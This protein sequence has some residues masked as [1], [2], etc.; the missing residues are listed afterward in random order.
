MKLDFQELTRDDEVHK[1]QLIL[2]GKQ[3]LSELVVRQEH[4]MSRLYLQFFQV[5]GIR[6]WLGY[7]V[8]SLLLIYWLLFPMSDIQ[9]ILLYEFL[10]GS[11][12]VIQVIRQRQAHMEELLCTLPI[13][14]ASIFLFHFTSFLVIYLA[15]LGVISYLLLYQFGLTLT[16]ILKLCVLPMLISQSV[17]LLAI[18][19]LDSFYSAAGLYLGAY[20]L[21]AL[22]F[23]IQDVAFFVNLGM[24]I[25]DQM[26]LGM[27]VLVVLGYGYIACTY[28]TFEKERTYEAYD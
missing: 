4:R 12:F 8:F 15:S 2:L 9:I 27:S 16:A 10:L 11:L 21:T 6:S 23:P 13:N 25:N 17:L 3:T 28:V 5:E 20:M 18:R 14:G 26:L 1:Q 7:L 24:V 22:L 19:Y